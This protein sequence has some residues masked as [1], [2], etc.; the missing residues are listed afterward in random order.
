MEITSRV[1]VAWVYVHSKWLIYVI[2]Q[3]VYQLTGYATVISAIINIALNFFLIKRIGVL[4]AAIASDISYLLQFLFH[5]YCAKYI[6]SK[7]NNTYPFS[8]RLLLSYLLIFLFFVLVA[9]ITIDRP[10]IRW[11]SGAILG[12]WECFRIYKRRAIF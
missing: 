11:V 1:S 12:I 5:S 10:V 4:G 6:I 7:G 3:I 2:I 9:F 8:S